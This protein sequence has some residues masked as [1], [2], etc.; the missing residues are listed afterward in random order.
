MPKKEHKKETR[1][2]TVGVLVSPTM[3]QLLKQ[4]AA[5]E[6]RTVS[7][8]TYLLLLESPTLKSRLAKA[9]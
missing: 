6:A 3:K 9:A 4:M 5:D 1:T 8:L 2:E 7:S